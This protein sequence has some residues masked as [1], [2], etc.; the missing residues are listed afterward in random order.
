M[1]QELT[2][3]GFGIVSASV[4]ALGAVGFTLQFG[5]SRVFNVAYGAMMTAAAYVAYVVDIDLHTSIWVGVVAGAVAGCL[6]GVASERCVFS[7]FSRRGS[8]LFTVVM[9]SLGLNVLV[10][11]GLIAIAG[12]SFYTYKMPPEHVY[13]VLGMVFTPTELI[14]IGIA[15]VAMLAIHLLLRATQLGKAMRATSADR[16]LASGCGINVALMTTVTWAL[17]G[18]LAGLGGVALAI[19]TAAFSPTSGD[20][21]VFIVF[22]AAVVG[23]LGQPYGAMLGALA[24]GIVTEEFAIVNAPL[25]YVGAFVVLIAMLIL[26]PGGL[27][28]IGGRSRRDA[29]AA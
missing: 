6:L 12:S 1:N 25:K 5:I 22:A 7:P 15:V 13:H 19:N 11:N 24:I 29:V 4:I 2:S 18:A 17:A 27:V 28:Q 23:G 20:Q 10:Q 16:E 14:L 8:N 21:F 26:R 9:V 3:L